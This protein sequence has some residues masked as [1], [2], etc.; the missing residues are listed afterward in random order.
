[1]GAANLD[2][3]GYEPICRVSATSGEKWLKTERAGWSGRYSYSD[4]GKTGFVMVGAPALHEQM[5][6]LLAAKK[7]RPGL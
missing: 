7:L 4:T 2:A 6:Q 5:R 3:N 1:M